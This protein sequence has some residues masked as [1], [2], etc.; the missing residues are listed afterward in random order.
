MRPL[1]GA[2]R[3]K[4]VARLDDFVLLSA[5]GCRSYLLPVNR[6]LRTLH[7]FMPYCEDAIIDSQGSFARREIASLVCFTRFIAIELIIQDAVTPTYYYV[8]GDAQSRARPIESPSSR[9][10]NYF[11]GSTLSRVSVCVLNRGSRRVKKRGEIGKEER[12]ETRSLKFSRFRDAIDERDPTNRTIFLRA[13]N[14]FA[15]PV[16]ISCVKDTHSVRRSPPWSPLFCRL[17]A[18]NQWKSSPLSADCGT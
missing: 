1:Q 6:T 3:R 10:I 14:P 15:E 12:N 11:R 4:E 2:G 17:D 13:N 5:T 9:L 16:T 18:D 7:A 8:S